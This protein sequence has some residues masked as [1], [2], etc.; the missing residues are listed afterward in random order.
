VIVV[1]GD[2]PIG[3]LFDEIC[4][5][6]RCLNSVSHVNDTPNSAA[7]VH[8]TRPRISLRVLFAAKDE[9][10]LDESLEP[11]LERIPIAAY[12]IFFGWCQTYVLDLGSLTL[13]L[14]GEGSSTEETRPSRRLPMAGDGVDLGPLLD[15]GHR[16]MA[17]TETIV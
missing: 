11:L 6:S 16:G 5:M 8:G 1:A 15:K 2:S 3:V 13:D 12:A 17:E 14:H 9:S 4:P 7:F 10:E